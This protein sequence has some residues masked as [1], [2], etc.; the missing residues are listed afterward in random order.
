MLDQCPGKKL[1]LGVGLGA[2]WEFV[3]LKLSDQGGPYSRR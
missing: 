2:V 1:S 3:T